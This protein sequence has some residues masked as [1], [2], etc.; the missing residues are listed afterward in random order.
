[1][2]IAIHQP[3]YW[4]WAG[5]LH[6]ALSAD[7]FV[8]LDVAQ[9]SKNGFQNRNHIKTRNGPAWLTL[10]VQHRFGQTIAQTLIAGRT[11]LD[12]HRKTIRMNYAGTAGFRRWN[13]DL[14]Q[15]FDNSTGSLCEL[16]IAST[17]WMLDRLG[18]TARRVRA[19]DLPGIGGSGSELIGSI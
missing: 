13:D 17:E 5:Y 14:G 16:A 19:S 2:R 10:P 18:A 8:Y 11:I 9:F 4:P 1:M 15:L 7:V 6:K 3:H 12:T